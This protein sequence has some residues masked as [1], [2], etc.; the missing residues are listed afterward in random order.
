[1][2]VSSSAGSSGR[3]ST[4]PTR[5]GL[6]SVSRSISR[7]RRAPC[8][9]MSNRPSGSWRTSRST[10]VQP[11][12]CRPARPSSSGA[13]PSRTATTPNSRSGTAPVTRSMVS[14]RYRGSKMCSGS[15]APGSSTVPSGNSGSVSATPLRY[16]AAGRF[17]RSA[18]GPG[19]AQNGERVGDAQGALGEAEDRGGTAARGARRRHLAG[20]FEDLAPG[21]HA[22][23]VRRRHRVAQR[24]GV[25]VAQGGD[26]ELAGGE[27][28][29]EVGV[30]QLRAQP[31][32][33]GGDDR[34]VVERGRRERGERVPRR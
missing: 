24:R 25:Q 29:P 27:R 33:G 2:T 1:P 22:L 21:Q 4:E 31:V 13:Q 16:V 32:A 26:R 11:T 8:V 34:G 17:A 19:R 3:G 18:G 30:G 15:V 5:Y 9:T 14:C 7:K 6:D 12:A 20:G 10:A 23:Q 28:E